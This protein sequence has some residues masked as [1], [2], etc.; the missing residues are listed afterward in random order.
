M[1][2]PHLALLQKDTRREATAVAVVS[3]TC[4]DDDDDDDAA[5][6][7]FG[8]ALQPAILPRPGQT[9]LDF[10][11]KKTLPQNSIVRSQEK[12]HGSSSKCFSAQHYTSGRKRFFYQRLA[13]HACLASDIPE[14]QLHRRASHD[15]LLEGEI[16]PDR[17]LVVPRKKVVHIS[18]AA[19]ATAVGGDRE[20]EATAVVTKQVSKEASAQGETFTQRG[21]GKEGTPLCEAIVL[22]RQE[23]LLFMRNGCCRG[24]AIPVLSSSTV[25]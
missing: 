18:A 23:R 6:S 24:V 19:A 1:A 15:E 11:K 5:C 3:F 4:S 7:L 21:Q 9:T 10:S 25:G 17:C 14:L 13:F 8:G 12:K 20:I 16:H 22:L 2:V